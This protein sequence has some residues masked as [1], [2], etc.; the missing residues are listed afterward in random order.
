MVQDLSRIYL[1]IYCTKKHL[2]CCNLISHIK[3]HGKHHKSFKK[4]SAAIKSVDPTAS[5]C[6]EGGRGAVHSKFPNW[7]GG[8]GTKNSKCKKIV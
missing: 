3:M 2:F 6:Y 4:W 8:L 5:G 1:H 7:G